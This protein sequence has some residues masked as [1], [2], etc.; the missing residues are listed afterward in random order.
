MLI[1]SQDKRQ[2]INFNRTSMLW[3]DDNE[4]NKGNKN[5]EIYADGELIAT[6]Q[7]EEKAEN[8]LQ[9]IME[10]YNQ[11]KRNSVYAMGDDGFTFEEKFY[12]E[13]PE[14]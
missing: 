8:V 2:I 4:I 6:Y 5:Y 14:D 10:Y 12:Y 3:I 7:T 1:M 9:E 13:M 11:L